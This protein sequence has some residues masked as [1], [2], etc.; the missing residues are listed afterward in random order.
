MTRL[1]SSFKFTLFV[2]CLLFIRLNAQVTVDCWDENTTNLP[3]NQLLSI[4]ASSNGKIYIGTSFGISGFNGVDWDTPICT[5]CWVSDI[6]RS[7]NGTLWVAWY[8]L[9]ATGGI[10]EIKP[11]STLIW[12]DD[13]T[14]EPRELGRHIAV[15]GNEVWASFFNIGA[16]RYDGS[17]WSYYN[18]TNS[19]IPSDTI[20]DIEANNQ[21]VW[22][23]TDKGIARF[24][25]NTWQT[26][27]L[28]KKA[29]NILPV[30]SN[31]VWAIINGAL[32]R[33][34]GNTWNVI[35]GSPSLNN[36]RDIAMDSQNRIW[37]AS[38]DSCLIVYNKVTNSWSYYNKNNLPSLLSNQGRCLA[39]DNNQNVW[40][41]LY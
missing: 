34:D 26:Y 15:N 28:G 27:Q 20:N 21:I 37:I 32:Y 11:D 9:A 29:I 35:T 30:S 1:V 4:Y 13:L 22:F 7:S 10:L 17:Q 3:S 38:T 5:S 24:H 6:D 33:F 8:S 39:I 40:G 16:V 14:P 18:R 19:A 23:A 36:A 41:R 12:H 31:E 2:S 25:N